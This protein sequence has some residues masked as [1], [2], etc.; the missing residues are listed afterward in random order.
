M[1]RQYS[2]IEPTAR[3]LD[4][5]ALEHPVF[6]G[7]DAEL[8]TSRPVGRFAYIN[9]KTVIYTHVTIGRY[10]S[11]A[12]N[13]EIGV[14]QHPTDFLSTHSFQYRNGIFRDH[15]IYAQIQ[16]AQWQENLPTIIGNDVW[17]GA[18]AIVSTGVTIGDGAIIAAG[19]VVTKD[20]PPY[21]IVG[22]V[23]AK[24]IRYRF[25]D[26]IIAQLLQLKWWD[27]DFEQLQGVPFDDIERA[28]E[29][30]RR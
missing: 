19:A 1:E 9:A 2:H 6:I 10:C 13:C 17:I 23:P 22:G 18:K 21:A 12:R 7:K 8:L 27:L 5:S 30:L 24:L 25:S 14:A 16:N 15:P 28:I 4:N 3:I 20:V 29:M 11:I 26:E